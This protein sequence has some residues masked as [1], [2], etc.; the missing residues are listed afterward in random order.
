MDTINEWDKCAM[1]IR[2]HIKSGMKKVEI[3]LCGTALQVEVASTPDE[4]QKGLMF[5]E[6]LAENEGMLFTF[7]Q[8][9][10]ASFWMANTAIPL[11]VGFFTTDGNLR[12]VYALKP[13][14]LNSV[15]SER[16][17]IQYA[18]EVNR[19]WFERHCG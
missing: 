6:N 17:D 19:G 14:D 4:Q 1:K 2:T 12:E 11:D 3:M 13:F 5:R 16:K 15:K 18:L 7:N 9:Q 10:Q 8:P